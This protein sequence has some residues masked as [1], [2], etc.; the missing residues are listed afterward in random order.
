MGEEPRAGVRNSDSAL[1]RCEDH[2]SPSARGKT[3]IPDR[4]TAG[5]AVLW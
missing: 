1:A 3:A 4:Y 2:V 5:M